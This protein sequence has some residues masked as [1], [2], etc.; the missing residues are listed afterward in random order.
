MKLIVL[1][2]ALLIPAISNPSASRAEDLSSLHA[3]LQEKRPE[4]KEYAKALLA[5]RLAV[6]T[7][8]ALQKKGFSESDIREVMSSK[9]FATFLRR[10]TLDPDIDTDLDVA[11]DRVLHPEAI[12]ERAERRRREATEIQ[13]SQMSLALQMAI[14]AKQMERIAK[15]PPAPESLWTRVWRHFKRSVIEG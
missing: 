12:R 1:I 7:Y 5:R 3:R 8:S 6:A 10:V 15:A 11:L 2:S 14:R 4:I 9:E 13:K